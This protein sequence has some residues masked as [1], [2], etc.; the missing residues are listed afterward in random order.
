MLGFSLWLLCREGSETEEPDER[1][2]KEGRKEGREGGRKEG[3][4]E[5]RRKGTKVDG[6]FSFSEAIC[7]SSRATRPQ[8]RAQ[9]WLPIS[10]LGSKVPI[11][12]DF[13]PTVKNPQKLCG[14]MPLF[15]AGGSKRLEL[16]DCEESV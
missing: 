10:F 5:G 9:I 16:N 4:K 3:R 13:L 7:G 12:P 14:I 2:R 8:Q 1:G 15:H 6:R 11:V